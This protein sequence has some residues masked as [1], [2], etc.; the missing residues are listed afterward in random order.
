MAG[1]AFILLPGMCNSNIII[2]AILI[3]IPVMII[4]IQD[5]PVSVLTLVSIGV[6]KVNFSFYITNSNGI[7]KYKINLKDV[8]LWYD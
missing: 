7:L 8:L 3:M 4:F 6:L 5:N 1:T 2:L